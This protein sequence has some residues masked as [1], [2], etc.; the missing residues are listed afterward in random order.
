[1]AIIFEELEQV[2]ATELADETDFPPELAQRLIATFRQAVF[3]SARADGEA[4]VVL[5]DASGNVVLLDLRFGTGRTERLERATIEEGSTQA[6]LTGA[7]ALALASAIRDWERQTGSYR[8]VLA[9][10][11]PK[12]RGSLAASAL[13]Q[14][15]RNALARQRFLREFPALTSAE[16]ADLARSRAA[17]RA[18]LANRWRDEGKVFSIR[19]GDQQLYPAFQLDDDGRP[20]EVIAA[21]L[22]EL[23]SGH[24]SDWQV[25]LWF[26]SPN[27]WLGGQPPVRLLA[28]QPV[29]VVAAAT[30][31]VGE[32]VA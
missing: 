25:A 26:A 19:V 27:G 15:R 12:D 1:M 32:L 20:L 4:D 21:V 18:S 29:G 10:L 24:L 8:D 31:E 5:E 16:I 28:D 13:L 9:A 23:S 14:A 3:D 17:N 22:G 2:I 7:V 11:A 6:V 30:R